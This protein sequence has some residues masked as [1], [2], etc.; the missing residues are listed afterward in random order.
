MIEQIDV[1]QHETE[2]LLETIL[3]NY[4]QTWCMACCLS[5]YLYSKTFTNWYLF[6]QGRKTYIPKLLVIWLFS[7][8]PVNRYLPHNTSFCT[9]PYTLISQ[10]CTF[11]QSTIFWLGVTPA[12]V[13]RTVQEKFLNYSWTVFKNCSS[14]VQEQIKNSSWTLNGPNTDLYFQE[15]FLNSSRTYVQKQFFISSRTILKLFL[16]LSR[17]V[18]H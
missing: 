12:K 6:V 15:Q 7:T 11:K 1:Y 5:V 3:C 9:D 18:L 14:L 8:R 13:S 4:W 2:R 16:N 17:T 10:K